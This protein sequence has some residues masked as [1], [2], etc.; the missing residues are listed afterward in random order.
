MGEEL[1]VPL[2]LGVFT[3]LAFGGRQAD[4]FVVSLTQ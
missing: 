4:G 1:G 2:G 3:G